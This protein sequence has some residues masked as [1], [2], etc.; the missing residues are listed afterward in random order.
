MLKTTPIPKRYR[1]IFLLAFFT[2]N[3]SLVQGQEPGI[4]NSSGNMYSQNDFIFEWSI[5]ELALVETMINGNII[6]T[7]GLL[8]PVLPIHMIT[9]RFIVF[10]TNILSP[11]GDGSNDFWVI[12]DLE[13]FPDNEL[14]IFDSAGR[15]LYHTRNYMNNWKG[16]LDN[17]PLAEG[18][19]YYVLALSKEGRTEIKKGFITIIN[20]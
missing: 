8:Q 9:E 16:T 20:D 18:T 17:A 11:N 10:P 14:R 1:L 4:V 12:K 2:A 5:G 3:S 15:V 7:N 13:K 19:Y 6:L